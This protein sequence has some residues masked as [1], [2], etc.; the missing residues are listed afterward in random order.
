MR[1]FTFLLIVVLFISF[2]AVG[3]KMKVTG[4]VVDPQ[5][6][7]I[8][9]AS[10]L[11][12]G[13]ST[14]VISNLDGIFT[15]EA[16]KGS[17][18][19]ISFVG[20]DAQEVVIGE[21]T[22]IT[23]QLAASTKNID[24]VVVTAL[25]IKRQEKSLT[26][27]TQQIKGK[28]MMSVPTSNMMNSLSGKAAGLTI[29]PSTSGAG[30]STKVILRGYTSIQ[31][32]NQ[33]LYVVDG[34]PL[35][36]YVPSQ[37]E[38]GNGFGGGV[39]AGDGISNLNPD[40]IESLNIL[41]GASA[42]ALYGSQA[43]NGVIIITTK[44][45]KSGK[46]VISYSA[47]MQF[48]KANIMYDFQNSYAA[49]GSKSWGAK[50]SFSDN[51]IEDFFQTGKTF[52]NS[53]SYSA[54]TEKSQNYLSYSYSNSNGIVPTNEMNKH[55]VTLK[56]TSILANGRITV[57]SKATF[58]NQQIDNPIAAPGQYYNPIY[59]LFTFPRGVDFD[60]Y[61][62]N[63]EIFSKARNGMVQNWNVDENGLNNPYWIL[64]RVPSI[65]KRTR[66]AF[67]MDV[68]LKLTD[69]LNLKARGTADRSWDDF[70]RKAYASTQNTIAHENGK[71]EISNKSYNEYY[72]D[73]LLSA[74]KTLNNFNINATIGT[75]ITDDKLTGTRFDSDTRGLYYANLFTVTNMIDGGKS[76]TQYDDHSQ[77]Q[78]VFGTASIGFKD[79]FYLDVTGRNDWSS[80]LPKKNN[81]YF[82]PS[83]GGSLLVSEL[84]SKT[85]KLPSF[86]D[87]A[88]VRVSYTEVGNDIAC[89]VFNPNNTVN[90]S[91]T[92]VR[93]NIEPNPDIKPERTQSQEVGLDLR[94]LKSRLNF[95]FTYY[96][97]N[98]KNQYFVI[99]NT[100][101][102][103]YSSR[104]IN[105]GNIENKGIELTVSIVPVKTNDITWTSTFNYA[106]NKSK[107]V[108]LPEQYKAEGYKLSANGYSLYIKEGGEYGEMWAK[109]YQRVDG[110]LVVSNASGSYNAIEST[111]EQKIG[112]VNPDYKL[113]WNNTITYKSF[114]LSF[115]I[116]GTFGGNVISITQKTLNQAG[117]TKE[118]ADARD[119]GGVQVDAVT[120]DANG[121]VNGTYTGKIDAKTYYTGAPTSE[122][123][124]D[125]TNI[126]LR[127]LS[128]SYSLPKSVYSKVKFVKD[129]RLS[130]VG[131]NLFFFKNNAPYD[132]ETTVST[133]GNY[134]FN[135]DNFGIPATRSFGMTLNVNF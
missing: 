37:A 58:L 103:G 9:G 35:V 119:N 66:A 14:G 7:P 83:I 50:K 106:K 132:P 30:S 16:S 82:Y 1:R 31:G 20:F 56:N 10:V 26:Y 13:T 73:L 4:K 23:V 115:L 100:S 79:M 54:G 75:S 62:N 114:A 39:D 108:E 131:R 102:S 122:F 94:F 112:T 101:G 109:Q 105:G 40:D 34:V 113:G 24:E 68:T 25:G 3:Q 123:I 127:E 78:S 49:D 107:V 61:K 104:Q 19:K 116:D 97:S 53:L 44:S 46:P 6:D 96:K 77:L 12:V 84:L 11:L 81:S 98:T 28:D 15:I 43:A 92:L 88:K 134:M 135:T 124:Y 52:M 27:A 72:G 59:T 89:Y 125:A 2:Q 129:V 5:N 17:T 99:S 70:E 76:R 91:G 111:T 117:V 51:H 71:Y 126:R 120:L 41:K 42:S 22:D 48:D 38:G 95:D 8:P 21:Q 57:N 74:A 130:L 133:T 55:T 121:K 32:N 36:N 93:N 128:L 67:T 18:L 65:A 110:K 63:F 29:S 47:S 90:E 69:W 85:G 64:Y 80:T 118:T 33:P 60:Q 86:L 45:G 87:F